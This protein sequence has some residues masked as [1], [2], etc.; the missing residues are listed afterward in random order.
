MTNARRFFVAYVWN[1]FGK[2]FIRGLGVISTLFIVRLLSPEDFGIIAISIMV[3][4]FF[5]VLTNCGAN[6]YLILH[7]SPTDDDFNSVWTLNILLRF[8]ALA[9]MWVFVPFIV[10]IFEQPDIKY[11]VVA[12]ACIQALAAFNNI[13]IIQQEKDMQLGPINKVMIVAKVASAIATIY[14]AWILR[15]FYALIIGTSVNVIVT[16]IGTYMVS[17]FRPKFRFKFKK[18]LFSFSS[19]LLIRNVVS[20]CRSQLDILLV[21]K[22]FG[23][24]AAGGYS[25][26]R[27]FATMPQTE[28]ITPAMQPLFSLMSTLKNRPKQFER[29]LYQT[30]FYSYLLIFPASIGLYFVAEPFVLTVLGEK[31]AFT[32]SYFGLLGFLMIIFLT[33]QALYMVYDARNKVIHSL[34]PDLLGILFM[35]CAVVL[36]QPANETIFTELRIFIAAISYCILLLCAKVFVGISI[37]KVIVSA[38]IPFF[39]SLIMALVLYNNYFDNEIEAIELI[40][41]SVIGGMVYVITVVSTMCVLFKINPKHDLIIYLPNSIVLQLKKLLI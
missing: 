38:A 30:Y 3:V 29:K 19:Y 36:Y 41:N 32:S 17:E 11:A 33:Q 28:I 22:L 13:G 15:N 27:Q 7:D 6:R 21:G 40:A 14:F 16:I 24:S 35:V 31:W 4:G 20:Y 12:M 18:D 37:I 10:V 1:M 34:I 2:L 8:V 39:A 26:A 23:T 5:A 9:A 25:I